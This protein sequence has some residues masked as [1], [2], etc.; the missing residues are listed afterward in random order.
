MAEMI[1]CFTNR[2]MA[3]IFFALLAV[4]AIAA[5]AEEAV[6]LDV[7]EAKIF[8]EVAGQGQPLVFI[9]A[10][11]ADSRQ[12]NNEFRSLS[13]E[14]NVLRYDMRGFGQS[15]PVDGEFSHLDD[16]LSLLDELSFDEPVILIGCSMG[17]AT[18]LDYALLHPQKV[19]ALVLVD[20][21]PSGL[22]LDLP[23]PP[24]FKLVAE[25]DKAGDLELVAELETQIWFDGDRQSSD[26][27]QTMRQLAYD[28][29]LI[30]LENDAR[31]LGTRLPNSDT[32]AIDRLDELQI[33]VL[34][35]VGDNDIPYM[36]AAAEAMSSKISNY[37]RVDIANAAHLPNM[38]QPE[39]FKRVLETF[40]QSVAR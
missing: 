10:G 11:V 33:P 13:T 38:D 14:Y 22:E 21:A 8:F 36:H 15:D 3:R 34:A 9:H 18:A 7:N 12:W 29:N 37:Q 19:R 31:E 23:T 5:F 40:I 39:E 2:V 20:S 32:P 28:M 35:I 24:K 25:A 27:D 26:V 4:N 17:G 1:G 6:M 16:L 30:A